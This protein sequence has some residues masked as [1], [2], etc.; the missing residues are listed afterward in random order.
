MIHIPEDP[1]SCEVWPSL[2]VMTNVFNEHQNEMITNGSVDRI[3]MEIFL[4]LNRMNATPMLTGHCDLMEA[5]QCFVAAMLKKQLQGSTCFDRYLV[6]DYAESLRNLTTFSAEEFMSGTLT[7][8]EG[9]PDISVGR[10][11]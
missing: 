7:H 4:E 9:L 3:A 2:T 8:R 11:C 1:I 10:R 5:A 6:S